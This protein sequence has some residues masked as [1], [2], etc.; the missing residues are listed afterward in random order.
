MTAN[1]VGCIAACYV[2]GQAPQNCAEMPWL[3]SENAGVLRFPTFRA[4]PKLGNLTAQRDSASNGF[5]R[6][7]RSPYNVAGV[8]D[9]AGKW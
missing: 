7:R 2:G 6:F 9:G 3:P 5:P 4:G 8:V 1:R